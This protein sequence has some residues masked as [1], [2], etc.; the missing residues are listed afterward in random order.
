MTVIECF[1]KSASKEKTVDLDGRLA[2]ENS[3]S[4]PVE[5]LIIG[6]SIFGLLL[7]FWMLMDVNQDAKS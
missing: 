5:A 6:R 3:H 2:V 1:E 4:T 7:N